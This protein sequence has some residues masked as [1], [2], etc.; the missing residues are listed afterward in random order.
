[1]PKRNTDALKFALKV[2]VEDA[3]NGLMACT[4][5]NPPT[6]YPSVLHSGSDFLVAAFL[7]QT[8]LV[9]FQFCRLHA[10]FRGKHGENTLFASPVISGAFLFVFFL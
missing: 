4:I 8:F 3:T 5:G 6:R 10:L 2:N 7:E 1:M 9:L